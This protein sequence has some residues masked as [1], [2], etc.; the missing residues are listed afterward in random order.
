MK[1]LL[2]FSIVMFCLVFGRSFAQTPEIEKYLHL[3]RE[4]DPN[5]KIQKEEWINTLHNIQPGVNWRLIESANRD[6]RHS[7]LSEQWQKNAGNQM[8]SDTSLVTIGKSGLTGR[9]IE[10][11]SN[12]MAGRMHTADMDFTDRQIYAASSGGNIWRGSYIGDEWTCLNNG[13]Q[14]GDIRFIKIIRFGTTKRIFVVGNGPAAAYFSDDEGKTWN[15][16]KGLDGPAS[17]GNT[18]RAVIRNST[19]EIYIL[20]VEWDYKAWKAVTYVN[21]SS[22]MGVTFTPVTKLDLSMSYCDIWSPSYDKSDVYFVHKDTLSKIVDTTVQKISTLSIQHNYSEIGQTL[23]QGSVVGGKNII[24]FLYGDNSKDASYLYNTTNEGVTMVFEGTAPTRT[25]ERNSF[26]VS[27]SDPNMAF[28]G[29][30]ELFRTTD[31]GVNWKKVNHWGDYYGNPKTLLHA[32]IPG[33]MYFRTP[34]GGEVYL[35][36]T[37][38][39][40]YIS[41]DGIETVENLSMSGLNVSQYYGSYTSTNSNGSLYL[42]SQDQGFQRCV[43]DTGGTL[44]FQQTISGDYGHLT[45]SDGGE[46]LWSVYPG[47]AMLYTNADKK[48]WNTYTLGFEIGANWLWMAPII[49]DLGNPSSAFLISGGSKTSGIYRNSL[50]W[51]LMFD[52]SKITFDTL[53]YNF[54]DS[55]GERKITAFA[56]SPLANSFWYALTNNGSFFFSTNDGDKWTINPT[57][58]G[59]DTHYFYGNTVVASKDKFGRLYIAG[60]GYSNP[61]VLYSDNHGQTFTP[62]DSGLPKTMV[63]KIAVTPDDKYIFAATDA[64]AFI[65]SFEDGRWFDLSSPDSPDQTYWSVEYVDKI[66]TARFVTYGR[67]VWDFKIEKFTSVESKATAEKAVKTKIQGYPNPFTDKISINVNCNKP[68]KAGLKIIDSEGRQIATLL[69]GYL[70]E[71]SNSFVWNCNSLSGAKIPAG[72]YIV[73]LLTDGFADFMKVVKQ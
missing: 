4:A 48:D 45:S 53:R 60:S 5:Y 19:N 34:Q 13:F 18:Q 37:D 57:F 35:I 11:G 61:G 52:G 8:L 33:V 24:S 1:R 3:N 50:I 29:G 7:K 58:D 67:G 72:T 66:K 49:A 23:M 55:S 27:H 36:G 46:H 64:G 65:Y 2:K 47:F 17:W 71:G 38:G 42:G 28:V 68:V 44:N 12:N 21:R 54:S 25:F 9:W 20:G 59:P 73:I 26:M 40:L 14:I 32:D 31:A 43:Q 69:D 22:D 41:K 51:R 70:N 6:A 62:I 56:Q 16:S 15:R 63:Y 39:G 10:K 30:V